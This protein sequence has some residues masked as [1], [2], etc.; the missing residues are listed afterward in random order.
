M[1]EPSLQ[2]A[3]ARLAAAPILLVASD[4]DGT[5][6]PIVP[7]P[8]D[9]RPDQASLRA[10]RSLARIESTHAA[11]V[12]GRARPDLLTRI[13]STPN[14]FLIGGHGG[15][16]PPPWQGPMIADPAALNTLVVAMTDIAAG[17]E[18]AIVEPKPT[19]VAVHY[20]TVAPEDRP[21]LRERVRAEILRQ[22]CPVVREGSMVIEAG[23]VRADKGVALRWL[24]GRLYAHATVFIGDDATDQDAFAVLGPSDVSIQVG[25][26][27]TKAAYRVADTAQV[28]AFLEALAAARAAHQAQRQITP[29]DHLALL[30]DQRTS[31]LVDPRGRVVWMCAPRFDSTPVFASVLGGT[32]AGHFD[33]AP[34]DGREAVSRAY[35]GDTF[36]L[37]TDYGGLTVT[38]YLDCSG[39]RPFQRAGRTDL[40]RRIEGSGRIVIRFAPRADFGRGCTRLRP[41]DE[42]LIVEGTLDPAA[43]RAPGVAWTIQDDGPDQSATATVDLVA[44]SPLVLE[45]RFGAFGTKPA[46]ADEPARHAGT[47]RF[48][49]SWASTLSLP[50]LHTDLV[51]RSALALKALCYAPTGAICAAATTSLPEQMGG[52]RNWDYRFCWIRD[53]AMSA[54]ALVRLGCTG[55]ALRYLD[56]L[57]AILEDLPETERLLPVYT[58][59]GAELG[60][61]GDVSE[62]PGYGDSRP[63][64]VGNGAAH[65]AQ[66]DVFGS[67]ADLIAQLAEVG[68]PLTPD[69]WRLLKHMCRA[70]RLR[71]MEPDH[72]IW[73]I[74]GP[75]RHHVHSKTMCWHTLTRSLRARHVTGEP[76]F[77][78]DAALA[79]EIRADV[80]THGFQPTRRAEGG[81]GGKHDSVCD[82]GCFTTAYGDPGVDAA[83]LTVG[84]TGLVAPDDPRFACTIRAVQTELLER[85]TVKRYHTDDGLPGVEG[86]FHLCTG[87]LIEALHLAG[88]RE[89]ARALLDEY[90]AQ[91]GPLGLY[92]EERCE[93][94]GR[95]LGNYPQAYSHIALI[96]ASVRLSSV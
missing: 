55:P 88:R 78:A 45:L 17:Y 48:W 9:A 49:E 82:H 8:D 53:G 26:G 54:G 64:R 22:N 91:A 56:W 33:V 21:R 27:P 5:I 44:G 79:E 68:S 35:D 7:L 63:V 31:A 18:G 60:Q 34:A 69:H 62:M 41:T 3:I 96:N 81:E 19:G 72:G 51:R 76:V 6:S 46:T 77:E 85:G 2:D 10:L 40:V 83:C 32:N 38:D 94:S 52:V 86:G 24:I 30:S 50:R 73:E 42:G 28:C 14:L 70:V 61:E 4:F 92:S 23:L 58:V 57:T 47:R 80:L 74:R 11:I 25:P 59:L 89:E 29:I 15:E 67:V 71:W 43:L 13:G 37:R 75:M 84:L 1:I 87:W 66:L 39:G 12:S 93:I 95:A 16:L 65:Q 20:R 90:A 36:T